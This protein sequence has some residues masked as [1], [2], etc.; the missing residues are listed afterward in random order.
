VTWFGSLVARADTFAALI[1]WG[2]KQCELAAYRIYG[3][4][5]NL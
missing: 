2:S 4:G 3:G 5:M 1:V